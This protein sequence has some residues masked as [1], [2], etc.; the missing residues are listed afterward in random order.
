MPEAPP[1]R[2][3]WIPARRR[4]CRGQLISGNFRGRRPV[5]QAVPTS[6]HFA[7]HGTADSISDSTSNPLPEVQR[8]RRARRR[9]PH[10]QRPTQGGGVVGSEGCQTDRGRTARPPWPVPGTVEERRTPRAAERRG[11]HGREGEWQKAGGS[12]AMDRGTGV[13]CGVRSRGRDGGRQGG[14]G[15]QGIAPGCTSAP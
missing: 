3:D 10:V 4:A 6:P 12:T 15:E 2:Q 11:S 9:R 7:P 8:Q 13:R 1:P 5:V 14:G